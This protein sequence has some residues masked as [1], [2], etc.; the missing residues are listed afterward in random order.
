MSVLLNE[1]S[2]EIIVTCNC[3]CM[4]SYHIM[5]DEMGDEYAFMSYMKGNFYTEMGPWRAFKRK[6]KKI[7]CIIRDKDYCYADTVM[8]K[9]DYEEFKRFVN[10][11]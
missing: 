8:S 1:K 3:G 7:W 5:V 9:E 11:F 10:Q 4:N 2:K 6:L